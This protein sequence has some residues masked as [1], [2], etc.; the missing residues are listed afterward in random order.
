MAGTWQGLVNQPTFYT[1][2]MILLTDGRV[3]VQEEDTP[4]W[5]AL[6]PDS[7]GSYINGTWSTLADMSFM[8]RYYASGVLKDG[9]VII[10]GGEQS[11][12]IPDTNKGEIYDHVLDT[13]T[14][15]PTPPG[16]SEVGDASILYTSRWKDYDRGSAISCMRY[17]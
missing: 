9:R 3:M 5:H 7:N 8:R 1:S 17:I 4:H 13:W 14:S 11:G 10:I 12:D 2:T 16:W 15:I 6:T